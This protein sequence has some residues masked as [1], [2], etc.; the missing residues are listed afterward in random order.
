MLTFPSSSACK[1]CFSN[2]AS[3]TPL[4]LDD[5]EYIVNERHLLQ[6]PLLSLY[7]TRRIPFFRW[8][9]FSV[10]FSPVV[11]AFSF[12]RFF[13]TVLSF[14]FASSALTPVSVYPFQHVQ[15]LLLQ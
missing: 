2:K 6:Q 4:S 11:A 10:F 8:S 12:F 14:S 3:L 9:C 15:L 1:P 5:V 7:S 13:S